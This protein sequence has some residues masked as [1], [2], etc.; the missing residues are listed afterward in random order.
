[1]LAASY[2]MY[3]M[4]CTQKAYAKHLSSFQLADF[5]TW[6]KIFYWVFP[7]GLQEGYKRSCLQQLLLNAAA[8]C[9]SGTPGQEALCPPVTLTRSAGFSCGHFLLSNTH[10]KKGSLRWTW[11]C[12]R[13]PI[14]RQACC[15]TRC[16]FFHKSLKLNNVDPQHVPRGTHSGLLR[17]WERASSNGNTC[18]S[19]RKRRYP[20]LH[21]KL[22]EFK[23]LLISFQKHLSSHMTHMIFLRLITFW[24]FRQIYYRRKVSL[25]TK[26]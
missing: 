3:C 21:S 6:I 23:A 15:C 5:P 13:R 11:T 12:F 22:K 2:S 18:H 7:T 20:K 19:A 26:Y 24:Q 14:W 1:M 17:Q 10:T 16:T 4:H 25:S 8:L 9:P